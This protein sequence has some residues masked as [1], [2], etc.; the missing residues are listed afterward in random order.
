MIGQTWITSYSKVGDGEV[1]DCPKAR[2]SPFPDGVGHEHWA[3]INHRCPP[4]K[5]RSSHLEKWEAPSIL[6]WC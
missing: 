3:E 6:L 4:P 1:Y 5:K 2:G